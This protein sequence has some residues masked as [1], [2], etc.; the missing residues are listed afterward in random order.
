MI[1]F[2]I[3]IIGMLVDLTRKNQDVVDGYLR[4]KKTKLPGFV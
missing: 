4:K 1:M 2:I 3:F